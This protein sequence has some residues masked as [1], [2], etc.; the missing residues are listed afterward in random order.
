[1]DNELAKTPQIE[2]AGG[3]TK[4]DFLEVNEIAQW[5]GGRLWSNQIEEDSDEGE[6]SEGV[7]AD[8]EPIE[9]DQ[10]GEEQSVNGNPIVT[11][12]YTNDEAINNATKETKDH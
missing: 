11:A 1:M 5:S 6:V 10:K 2:S 4:N 7:P 9:D 3:K 12:K 8:E